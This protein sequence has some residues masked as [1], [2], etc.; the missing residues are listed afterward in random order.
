MVISG[1]LIGHIRTVPDFPKKGIMF[2]DITTLLAEPEAFGAAIDE[3]FTLYSSA[4]ISKVVGIESRGFIFAS[5]LAYKMHAGLVPVRKPNKLPA[6]TIREEYQ[7]EYG[8]D[9]LEMHCDSI[10]TGERVLIVD[11][12][13]ATGGTVEA[14]CKLV[15]RMGGTIVGLAFLIELTFLNGRKRLQN[16]DIHSLVQYASE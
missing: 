11:D 7:L 10:S 6:K 12:L 3:M 16:Y 2:R 4:R 5:A 15:E 14:A 9:A 8:N 1:G 13:L